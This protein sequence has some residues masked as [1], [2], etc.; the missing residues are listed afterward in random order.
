MSKGMEQQVETGIPSSPYALCDGDIHTLPFYEWVQYFV[1]IPYPFYRI[2]IWGMGKGIQWQR[3][4]RA[5]YRLDIT[6]LLAY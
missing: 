2:W 4:L 5:L 3:D 1:F 6:E